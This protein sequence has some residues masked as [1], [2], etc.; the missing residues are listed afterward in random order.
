MHC[1]WSSSANRSAFLS[2][3]ALPSPF[4]FWV[5][6]KA[7]L[8]LISFPLTHCN[9]APALSIQTNSPRSQMTSF[10]LTWGI[11][12]SSL[13]FLSNLILLIIFFLAWL[14][15]QYPLVA[16]HQPSLLLF[17]HLLEQLLLPSSLDSIKSTTD[18]VFSLYTFFSC[19]LL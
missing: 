17:Q 5:T 11:S 12:V 1:L 10:W 13:T 15:W 18:S 4:Q 7:C 6:W 16:F 3:P 2:L 9:L 19:F 8:P 14:L